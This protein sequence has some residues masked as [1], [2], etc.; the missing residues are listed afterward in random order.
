[1][2]LEI[3]WRVDFV[4]NGMIFL[5]C[6]KAST[7]DLEGWEFFIVAAYKPLFTLDIDLVAHLVK[8]SFIR[9]ENPGAFGDRSAVPCIAAEAGMAAAHAATEQ[10]CQYDMQVRPIHSRIV[11]EAK[12]RCKEIFVLYE[13]NVVKNG[14]LVK[15]FLI[16]SK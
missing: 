13:G 11:T 8:L 6:N 15:D 9:G 10:A 1:M 14:G 5:C 3:Y 4:F 2:Y 12:S 7:K 16:A